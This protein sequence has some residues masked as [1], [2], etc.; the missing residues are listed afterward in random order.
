MEGRE[1]DGE[2]WGEE[3]GGGAEE[4]AAESDGSPR[5]RRRWRF[6]DYRLRDSDIVCP[7]GIEA[8]TLRFRVYEA[9]E[10]R[11]PSRIPVPDFWDSDE[12]SRR[13]CLRPG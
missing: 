1:S 3:D 4:G 12:G 5:G 9:G 10:C 13:R 2:D 11:S 6:G 7:K 8:Q